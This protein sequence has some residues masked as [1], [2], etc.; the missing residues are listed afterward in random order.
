MANKQQIKE[1]AARVAA[2]R[3]QQ[4]RKDRRRKLWIFG[5]AAVVCLGLIAAVAVPLVGGAERR[6]EARAAEAEIEAA[7]AGPIEGVQEFTGLTSNHVTGQVDYPMT[8]AAG[9]DHNAVWQNCG[10]YTEPLVNEHAVHSLEHG[11]VWVTYSP[12]LPADQVAVLTDEIEGQNY[13]LLSP[14]E[15][16][17]SPIFM[18]A[19][20]AQL[21]LDDPD[22]PRFDVFLEKY[23]QGAQTPEPGAACFGGTGTPAA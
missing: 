1:R 19:W 18:S 8:P 17:A 23:L 10:V 12:D 11:A 15:G 14:H 13:G 2:M 6:A 7:A 9:G 3:A 4:E 16:Q 21:A 22:D 5:S 20:G